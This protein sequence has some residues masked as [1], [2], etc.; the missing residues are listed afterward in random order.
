MA[1]AGG[2]AAFYSSAAVDSL[3]LQARRT[4]DDEERIGMYARADSLIQADAPWIF[5]VHPV[6]ADIVQPWL[7]GYEMPRVFYANKWLDVGLRGGEEL[8]AE[9]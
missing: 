9:R 4:L 2:N 3:I 8:A 6:D 7:E 1:G 5:T